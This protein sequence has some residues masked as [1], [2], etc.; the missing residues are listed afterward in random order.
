M[1]YNMPQR[2]QLFKSVNEEFS[3]IMDV[4]SKYSIHNAN[5]SF[6]LT[7]Q[8]ENLSLRTPVNSTQRENIRFMVP[9]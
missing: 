5:I 7:K 8:G 1:F 9:K 3:R 6:T 2:K 4:V